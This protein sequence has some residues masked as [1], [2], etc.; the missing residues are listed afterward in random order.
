MPEDRREPVLA[1][2][3]LLF[4]L[5][6]IFLWAGLRNM[7]IL[8]VSL[9][10]AFIAFCGTVTGYRAHRRIRR[11]GGRIPGEAISMVGYYS[12]LVLFLLTLLLFCYSFAMAVLRGDIL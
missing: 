9:A 1:R 3:S 7:D 6:N 2:I 12:N 5:V 4:L 8:V 10:S 11:Y